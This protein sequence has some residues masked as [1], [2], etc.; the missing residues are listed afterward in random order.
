MLSH[1]VVALLRF[2]MSEHVRNP[3]SVIRWA[4]AGHWRGWSPVGDGVIPDVHVAGATTGP[5]AAAVT[6]ND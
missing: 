2:V 3:R 5:S 6:G 1:T 4:G